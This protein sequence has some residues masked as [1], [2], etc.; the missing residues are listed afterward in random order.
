[1]SFLLF[2]RAREFSSVAASHW[3]RGWDGT[4]FVKIAI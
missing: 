3:V 2:G 4:P 1:M